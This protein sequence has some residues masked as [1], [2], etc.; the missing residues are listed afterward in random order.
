MSVK[1]LP[2]LDESYPL[3]D[4]ADWQSSRDALVKGTPTKKFAKESWNAIVDG[5]AEALEAAGL[6]WDETY[7]TLEGAKITAAY[8]KL[9]AQKFNSV[10][11]NI[12]RPAPLGWV[13]EW[14]TDF[15]G[16]VGRVDFRGSTDYGRDCD[17]V[18]PEYIIELVRKLNLLLE[19]LRGTAL[20]EDI[21]A[22]RLSA[23]NIDAEAFAGIGAR[24]AT[25]H[26]S[27]VVV[28]AQARSAEGR[29]MAAQEESSSMAAAEAVVK[30]ALPASSSLQ[31]PVLLQA[32]GRS[33]LSAPA[34]PCGQL[35]SCRVS[36]EAI[37]IREAE[38]SAGK[39]STVIVQADAAS[40]ESL[41][42]E[43]EAAVSS[44]REAEALTKESIP[45]E[46]QLL[47]SSMVEAE[48]VS[49]PSIPAERRILISSMSQVSLG[50]AESAVAGAEVLVGTLLSG[51]LDTAWYP[52]VWVDGG[53]WIRQSH[54]VTQNENGELVIL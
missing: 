12:D 8:G 43:V 48:V 31:I 21:E 24:V 38:A 33:R 20:I 19:L 27:P 40:V 51:E 37:A 6:D 36:A 41:P 28:T 5:L 30:K 32:E 22:E 11:H 29:P 42:A 16:Y 9:T 23:L 18:Y 49:K 47:V 3:Y 35:I 54:N 50:G 53:L 25:D 17:K 45:A 10:R 14:Q 52:P 39:L 44:I 1:E 26:I 34:T 13:W 7:T 15:R 2:L 46:S 4:W